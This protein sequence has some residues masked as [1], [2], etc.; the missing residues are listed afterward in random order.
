[1]KRSF[2]YVCAGALAL[3][4]CTNDEVIA[5]VENSGIAIGF[6]TV[7]G[8][9]AS[10]VGVTDVNTLKMNNY[11]FSVSAYLHGATAWTG[12]VNTA[13]DFMNNEK[14]IW[15]ANDPGKWEYAPLK[16][17]PGKVNG[18]DYGYVTFFGIGGAENSKLDI[19]YTSNKLTCEYTNSKGVDAQRD[20]VANVQKD[21]RWANSSTTV[22]FNFKHILSRI[23]FAA[24]MNQAN[25]PD[26]T[27]VKVTDLIVDYTADKIKEK[28][29]YNFEMDGSNTTGGSWT[30]VSS[31]T[32]LSENSTKLN[33]GDVTLSITNTDATTLNGTSK[34]LMLI[35]QSIASG[36]LVANLTYKIKTKK[37]TGSEEE[38]TYTIKALLPATNFLLGKAY[39]FTFILTLN[40]VV[41]DVTPTFVNWDDPNNANVNI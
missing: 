18:S 20:L 8:P 25:Y 2:L 35:P 32:Y 29:V 39:N 30:D 27:E 14:V 13:P 31:I 17:W 24:K 21:Q 40:P 28:G 10:R 6:G 37:G 3:A 7:T 1:M 23:G 19:A 16:Y 22:K 34:Y 9:A 5:P 26:V 11:G 38:V 41:F 12:T 4:A 15:N 36:D 33:D